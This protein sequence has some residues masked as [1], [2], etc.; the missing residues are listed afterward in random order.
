VYLKERP[1]GETTYIDMVILLGL[2]F[3]R[4]ALSVGGAAKQNTDQLVR[5]S[6]LA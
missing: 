1:G 5:L 6:L 4:E 3:Y 2:G